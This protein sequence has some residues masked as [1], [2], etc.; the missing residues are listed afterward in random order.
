MALTLGLDA[1]RNFDICS[2]AQLAVLLA[3]FSYSLAGVWAKLQLAGQSSE[4][5]ALGMLLGSSVLMIPTALWMDGL[6]SFNLG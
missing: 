6:P 5:N 4:M 2:L 1:L 3:G